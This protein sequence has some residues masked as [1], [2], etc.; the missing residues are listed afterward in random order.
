MVKDPEDGT[1]ERRDH[2]VIPPK[3]KNSV[4]FPK[5]KDAELFTVPDAKNTHVHVDKLVTKRKE[6]KMHSTMFQAT[7]LDEN[8][9][10]YKILSV[11]CIEGCQQLKTLRF[12]V[13]I[14]SQVGTVGWWGLVRV[15]TGVKSVEGEFV[16]GRAFQTEFGAVSA[17]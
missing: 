6:T 7:H 16:R 12:R 5:P 8:G 14:N 10:V 9:H 2:C 13:H 4:N 15:H 11:E 17:N 3:V 1:F